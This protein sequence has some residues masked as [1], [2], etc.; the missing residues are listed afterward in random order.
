MARA[1]DYFAWWIHD[2]Y[3][4]SK[5]FDCLAYMGIPDLRTPIIFLAAVKCGYKL[6]LLSQRN[7]IPTNVSLLQQTRCIRLFHSVE[8]RPVIEGVQGTVEQLECVEVP[9]LDQMLE[10]ESQHYPF[11]E[12]F[13]IAKRNPIVILHSSG[14]TGIPKTVTMTHGTFATIDND[15]NMPVIEG[16]RNADATIWDF[17]GEGK[18]FSAF[19]PSH[20]AG[21]VATAVR[22]IYSE[23]SAPVMGPALRP[24]TGTMLKEIM[25]HHKLQGLYL[26]PTIAEQLLQEPGGLDNFRN[27]EFLCYAGGPLAPSAGEQISKVIDVCTTYGGTETGQI[28]QLFPSREDWG[29]MEWH[30]AENLTMEPADDDAYELVMHVSTRTEG[31]SHLNHNFPGMT[32]Y[33]TRDL[34]RPHPNKPNLWRFHGRR[35]D[36]LVLS[37]GEKFNPVPMEVIIQGDPRVS[38]ALVV[39]QGRFQA[40]LL[41]EPKPGFTDKSAL[42]DSIWPLVEKGNSQLPS[43]GHISRSK[44]FIADADKPF[45]RAGKGTVVRKFTERDYSTE[46][47]YLYQ[48]NSQDTQPIGPILKASYDHESVKDFVR[49]LVKAC[50]PDIRISDTDDLYVCGLDSLKTYEI[51][52]TLQTNLRGQI[53]PGDLSWLSDNVIYTNASIDQLAT[54]ISDFLNSGLLPAQ[55][56]DITIQRHTAKMSALVD[57][58]TVSLPQRSLPRKLPV[59]VAKVIALTGSTGT[60]GFHLLRKLID[61]PSVS[62]IFCLD[63]ADNAQQRN[64]QKLNMC[65]VTFQSPKATY[66][67]AKFAQ[68]DLG[69][70]V[71]EL[72]ELTRSVDIIIH[73]AW[74]VDFNA[75]LEAFEDVHIRG[76]RNIIDWSASSEKQPRIIFISSISS[77][78]NW[79]EVH[80]EAK[81][82]P[83]GPLGDYQVASSIGYGESKNVAE[84]LLHAASQ[85]SHVPVS[86]LRLGQVAGSTQSEDPSWPEQ[87]WFPS[88][89]KTSKSLGLLPANI[90]P[91]DW[92]PVNRMADIILELAFSDRKSGDNEKIYNLVN[93]RPTSWASV[94]NTVRVHLGPQTEIVPFSIWLTTL[95]GKKSLENL[96]SMPALK[97]LDFFEGLENEKSAMK[98]EMKHALE[99]SKSMA[100][101][102]SINSGWVDV[103]L[104]KWNF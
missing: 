64:E 41:I 46:I 81:Q 83:E 14:S 93:P 18:F 27:L 25:Q 100:R 70:T 61:D 48:E 96:S 63:R 40:A 71:S 51:A 55:R 33:R 37:N 97:I 9:S 84:T 99:T 42:K 79:A 21:F 53:A 60:L 78:S 50:L 67:T 58:Y 90:P 31:M 39:G 35:D 17:A 98:Y 11:N 75:P 104:K 32:E 49:V 72:S 102:D 86:I 36:I 89:I 20:L 91:L 74:K 28:H 44:I 56:S 7:A 3:G 59:S 43:Q 85:Q 4:R 68:Q 65:G 52:N 94:L 13:D 23:A 77:A 24:A 87:E 80:G 2:R 38:G 62:R 73:N 1:T 6:L 29:F 66:L 76:T 8:M 45:Q 19:P 92:I 30:P 54:V 16:R 22:P 26:P 69:L 47:E 82:V 15:R 12:T 10:G 34:F 101:L 103:W 95:K 5:E 57:R 88:L